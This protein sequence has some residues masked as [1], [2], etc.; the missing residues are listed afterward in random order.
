VQVLIVAVYIDDDR[1]GP[2]LPVPR[3]NPLDD[4]IE[5]MRREMQHGRDSTT[6]R[7]AD[8]SKVAG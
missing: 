4:L 5:R 2:K 6:K 1:D 3:R 8:G 7:I